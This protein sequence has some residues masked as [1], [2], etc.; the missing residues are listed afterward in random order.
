MICLRPRI[1]A[2]RR[3]GRAFTLVE[4][5]VVVTIIALLLT[6]LIPSMGRAREMARKSVC[7]TRMKNCGTAVTTFVN[8]RGNY[9]NLGG[10]NAPRDTWPKFNEVMQAMGIPPTS[11]TNKFPEYQYSMPNELPDAALCPSMDLGAMWSFL[12]RTLWE[13]G[14]DVETKACRFQNAIAFQ[15]NVCLRG[16]GGAN[17]WIPLGRVYPSAWRVDDYFSSYDDGWDNTSQTDTWLRLP[18]GIYV[19][20]AVR[21][22]EVENPANCA[23]AWDS[24]DPDTIMDMARP[25]GDPKLLKL[26]TNYL[27][28]HWIPGGHWGPAT[29][30]ASGWAVLNGRRHKGSPNILYADGSVREDATRLLMPSDLPQWQYSGLDRAWLVSWPDKDPFWGSM[31]HIVPRAEVL[32]RLPD[33]PP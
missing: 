29:T 16:P 24:F 12:G 30:D 4:L 8:E 15:W 32:P 11:M 28:E 5:L 26:G 19:A 14:R 13:A 23:E 22:S 6:I 27:M 20:Q 2:G 10:R 17:A 7:K 1:R 33:Q 9:P 3:R 18:E 31:K 21:S 25:P